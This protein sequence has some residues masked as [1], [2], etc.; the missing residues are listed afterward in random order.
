M[1]LVLADD[2]D[3]SRGALLS[4]AAAPAQLA[5]A[6]DATLL[7]MGERPAV[8]GTSYLIKIGTRTVKATLSR[9]RSRVDL[10]T[11]EEVAAERFDLNDIGEAELILDRPVALDLYL[12]DR[13][14]GGFIVIDRESYDTVGM[15]LV[16]AARADYVRSRMHPLVKLARRWFASASESSLRSLF[17]AVTWRVCGSLDTT[18][19]A[20]LFTG[21]LKVSAAIG[22]TEVLTKIALYYMHERFWTRIS[23]GKS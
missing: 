19:L 12:E 6:V 3:I 10:G 15:G 18:V 16:R 21:N 13:S 20:F 1:T 4:S 14:T 2:V 11:L 7:W 5:R 8:P 22:G 9:I 17:K 23:F